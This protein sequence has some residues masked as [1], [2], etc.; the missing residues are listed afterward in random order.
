MSSSNYRH[1]VISRN[2]VKVTG[3]ERINT[4]RKKKS[5]LN[6]KQS[7]PMTTQA[8]DIAYQYRQRAKREKLLRLADMNFEAGSCVFL[9]ATFKENVKDYDTAVKAFK[10]FTKKLRRKLEDVRYIATLEIQK[11][12]AY[13]FHILLN[14]P[15]VQFCLDNV[16][17]LWQNGI[18]DTQGVTDVRKTI[19]YITKDL[20]IQNRNHPLYNRR[21]YFVS[22]G[23][24]P[25][26]E[27]SSWNHSTWQVQFAQQLITGR[28]PS[29]SNQVNS[30]DAGL[31]EYADYYFPTNIFQKPP[32]AKLRL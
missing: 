7:K 13:H 18:V 26:I 19:L 30:A 10:G 22:Q 4:G 11:R 27:I 6:P 20:V 3:Y 23:L 8:L 15:D 14:A 29:K 24:I 12:G 21:C 31:V 5:A 16:E 25:C 17:P 1:Y 32:L 28:A 9:T 2:F